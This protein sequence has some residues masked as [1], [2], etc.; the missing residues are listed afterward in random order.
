M[1]TVCLSI[2]FVGLLAPHASAQRD[3]PVSQ[4][5]LPRIEI[6][7]E[8]DAALTVDLLFKTH[9]FGP[10]SVRGKRQ[11][12]QLLLSL[13]VHLQK[14]GPAGGHAETRKLRPRPCEYRWR[15]TN[16]VSR[17]SQTADF[18]SGERL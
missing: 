17:P 18:R 12:R 6:Y 7:H 13:Q 10:T 16:M 3:P 15:P 8:K 14:Q 1:K 4:V 11:C 9:V 2:L 5:Y